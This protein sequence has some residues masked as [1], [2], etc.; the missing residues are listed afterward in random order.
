MERHTA[1]SRDGRTGGAA[2]G[3][4]YCP[5]HHYRCGQMGSEPPKGGVIDDCQNSV[6]DQANTKKFE[7]PDN[8]RGIN[9]RVKP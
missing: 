6:E 7:F 5:G 3:P 2:V 9:P 4:D 1:T 8:T